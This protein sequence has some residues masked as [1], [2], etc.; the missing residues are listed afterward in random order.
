MVMLYAPKHGQRDQL[1][2]QGRN[3]QSWSVP[4]P[5]AIPELAKDA[6]VVVQQERRTL[7]PRRRLPNLLLHPR[8]PRV[9]RRVDEDDAAR[10][11]LPAGLRLATE[12][13]SRRI[14]S[15]ASTPAPLL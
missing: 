4:S 10:A 6:I 7:R 14:G 9:G 15:W 13:I 1:A 5:P 2:L 8:E 3:P 11:G 12:L